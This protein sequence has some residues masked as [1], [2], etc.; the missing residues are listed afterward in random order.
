MTD[1]NDTQSALTNSVILASDIISAYV[2]R[3]HVAPADL[4]GL[5][6]SVHASIESLGNGSAQSA[7]AEEEV[8]K[9][10]PAQIRKSITPDGLISFI[11]GKA[12]KTLKRHLSTNGLD[13]YSYRARYGLPHDYPMV[14]AN[15]AAQRSQLAK[16]LGLGRTG[17]KPAVQKPEAEVEQ[18]KKPGRRKPAAEQTQPETG[19]SKA[20][21]RSEPPVGQTKGRGRRKA[22]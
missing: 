10:T 21:S 18:A 11:D 12:Y 5:L 20:G 8:E 1:K 17:E 14:D 16:A 22:A 19:Q 4:P 9:P 15:Y 13:P 7:A 6:R 2:V 3:N